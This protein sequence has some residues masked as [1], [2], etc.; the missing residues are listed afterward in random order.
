MINSLGTTLAL[1]NRRQRVIYVLMVVARS[2]VSFLDV[3][4]IALIGA[5]SG[6]AA[7]SI[8]GGQPVKLL[9]VQLPALTPQ[10]LLG[11]AV[12]VLIVFL[13]KGILAISLAKATS[14]WVSH[15]ES[16]KAKEI[17]EYL[18]SGSLSDLH[19]RS[20]GEI[21]WVVMGSTSFAIT[22]LLTN[23]AT[24]ISESF[25]LVAV[26]IAFALID[27]VA[28]LFVIGYFGLIVVM[29][30]LFIGARLRHAGQEAS[31]GNSA[32]VTAIDDIIG[33][34]R[35]IAVSRKLKYFINGFG[36][37]R[38][39]LSRSDA[40][41]SFL[42][43]MPRYVVETALMLGVVLFVGI[44]FATGQLAS[45]L[46]TVG[47]F[48]T[49]G[50]RIMSS[51]LPL[52]NAATN[53]KVNVERAREAQVILTEMASTLSHSQPKMASRSAGSNFDGGLALSVKGVSYAYP[54]AEELA[55]S[56]VNLDVFAGQHVAIIGP[57]GAG[58][59]TLVDLLLGLIVPSRGEVRIGGYP[60][61]DVV[62][63]HPG[64]IAYVP[65]NP[66]L[67]TGSIAEN[68]ALGVPPES[69]DFARLENVLKTAHLWNF[70]ESLPDGL[71]TT[72]GKHGDA[73]SG[74]QIQRL[75]LARALYS[76]PKVLI[77]DEATSALDAASEANISQSLKGL[78]DDVTI[79]VIAHRLSTV[80]HSDNVFVLEEGKITA[81]GDFAFL[82]KTVPMVANYV[83][84]MSF[85]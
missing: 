34:Y 73:L 30:Q 20:K 62:E 76:N 53:I 2:L 11:L 16:E 41:H 69:I 49:G 59:T 52:Q 36:V 33:S 19:L 9:G 78:G 83:Q 38:S 25:L 17:A 42:G 40:A 67:V 7:S 54:G 26:I 23:M 82:R 31:A 77:L 48:L 3:V 58:K 5:I 28:T 72:V 60:P 51:L 35:E 81:S 22:G 47:V 80:Q 70:V 74:G 45:G 8:D 18:L 64:L 79:V 21:L 50:V 57:S 85:D 43:G 6:I 24:V 55:L 29:I 44:Q 27:P 68:V 13:V 71:D 32:S 63:Q 56:N 84:L 75:G 46:V 66:G 4:G 37:Q 61:I 39:R 65:Q 12:T 10:L 14:V 1:L 15:I